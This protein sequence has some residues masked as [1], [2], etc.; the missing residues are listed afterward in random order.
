MTTKKT[1]RKLEKLKTKTKIKMKIKL[2]RKWNLIGIRYGTMRRK[3]SQ[4]VVKDTEPKD[5]AKGSTEGGRK[6]LLRS[7]M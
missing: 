6:K 3:K 4:T 1:K 7:H 5:Q 2:Q